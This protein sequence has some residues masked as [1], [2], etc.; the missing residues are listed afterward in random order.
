MFIRKLIDLRFLKEKKKRYC[1]NT[2]QTPKHL[3]GEHH[4]GKCFQQRKNDRERKVFGAGGG[5]SEE[6]AHS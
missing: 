3:H 4:L 1:S 2:I 6:P 5:G